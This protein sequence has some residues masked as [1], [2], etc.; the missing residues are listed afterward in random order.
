MNFVITGDTI[1][2]VLVILGIVAMVLL[3][4]ILC[5]ISNL[6]KTTHKKI[7]P[8]LENV[9]KSSQSSEKILSVVA[10]N[11][12][13]VDLLIKAISKITND[14]SLVTGSITDIVLDV[15]E[16]ITQTKG[17]V[18]TAKKVNEII[19]KATNEVEPNAEEIQI[20]VMKVEIEN[21]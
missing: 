18:K 2:F 1:V 20:N 17:I 9:E 13:E 16:T 5:R 3:I 21:D 7:I 8:I 6:I 14:T 4:V 19:K 10:K 12:V 15:K 11:E